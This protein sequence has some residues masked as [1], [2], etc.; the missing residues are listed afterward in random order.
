MGSK[1]YELLLHGI[2]IGLYDTH[3]GA[4]DGMQ[5]DI[6]LGGFIFNKGIRNETNYDIVEMDAIE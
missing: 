5:K 4:V 6:K 1:K 3:A 2:P